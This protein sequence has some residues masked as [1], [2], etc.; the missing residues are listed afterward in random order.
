MTDDDE[1]LLFRCRLD[2]FFIVLLCALLDVMTFHSHSTLC[3]TLFVAPLD[4]V[5]L[6]VSFCIRVLGY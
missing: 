3:V 5:L 4:A 6:S 1:L 2:G